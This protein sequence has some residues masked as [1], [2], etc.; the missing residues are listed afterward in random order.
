MGGKNAENPVEAVI[1]GAL[2]PV[3]IDDNGPNGQFFS[4]MDYKL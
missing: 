2:V 3:L 1:P 4:A